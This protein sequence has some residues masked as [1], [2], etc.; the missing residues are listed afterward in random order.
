MPE[1][2]IDKPD[3]QAGLWN[4][5]YRNNSE[6]LPSAAPVLADNRHLL[7]SAGCALDLACGLGGNAL[8]LAQHGLA[9]WAWDSSAVAI[10]KVSQLAQ[11]QNLSIQTELRDVVVSPPTPDSFDVITVSRFLERSL[12]AALIAA[13]KPGGLLFYQT[14]TAI[15]AQSGGP[16]NPAYLLADNELLHLFAGL[17]LRVY[18]EENC[19]GDPQQGQRNTAMLVAEQQTFGEL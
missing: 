13:L 10:D 12:A 4:Q 7:P 17:R 6:P 3:N 9:V 15:K 11:T 18:R 2:I 14:F 1:T 16:S 8:L 5:R 19:L